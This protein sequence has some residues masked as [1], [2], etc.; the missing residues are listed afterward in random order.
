MFL[1]YRKI[2]LFIKYNYMIIL[3]GLFVQ[4]IAQRTQWGK[5]QNFTSSTYNS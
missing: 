1:I 3:H 5:G 4:R 2:F